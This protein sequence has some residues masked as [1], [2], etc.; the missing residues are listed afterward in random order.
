MPDNGAIRSVELD[1]PENEV[2][3]T[4][5]DRVGTVMINR[6]DRMNATNHTLPYS[7]STAMLKAA[8][9]SERSSAMV[10]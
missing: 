7:V 4:I 1:V 5:K 3:F 6:P 8:T 9:F 2:L 10:V